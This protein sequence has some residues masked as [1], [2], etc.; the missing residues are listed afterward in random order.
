MHTI[1][2]INE[3]YGRDIE[4]HYSSGFLQENATGKVFQV[5]GIDSFESSATLFLQNPRRRTINTGRISAKE[6]SDKFSA[7]HL[8][9]GYVNLRGYCV[10]IERTVERRFK[11][12]TATSNTGLHVPGCLFA[13]MDNKRHKRRIDAYVVLKALKGEFYTW[14]EALKKLDNMFS[15][16]LT[17]ALCLFKLP[18]YDKEPVIGVAYHNMFIGHLVDEVI[19]FKDSQIEELI[20]Q[21]LRE[22]G[23][24]A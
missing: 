21:Q 9:D 17:P 24:E 8:E 7:I 22:A 16:A 11:K 14:A 13:R 19:K 4:M 3:D 1:Y 18:V 20:I 10:Y 23:Y 6:F 12:G 2:P 15:V 5:A